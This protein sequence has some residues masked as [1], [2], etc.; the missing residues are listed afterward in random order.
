MNRYFYPPLLQNAQL[1]T[2]V[3]ISVDRNVTL[4]KIPHFMELW[5]EKLIARRVSTNLFTCKMVSPF[6]FKIA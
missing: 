1:T 6:V 5:A 3:H 2:I 4:I